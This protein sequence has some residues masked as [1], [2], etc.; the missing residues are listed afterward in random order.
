[1]L[2]QI[3]IRRNNKY[4]RCLIMRNCLVLFQ[5]ICSPRELQLSRHKNTTTDRYRDRTSHV[6]PR[7]LGCI[8]KR[9]FRLQS[10]CVWSRKSARIWLTLTGT[11]YEGL[12][13]GSKTL[14]PVDFSQSA[15]ISIM[16]RERVNW[17]GQ[18]VVQGCWCTFGPP[19]VPVRGRG[20]SKAADA[21]WERSLSQVVGSNKQTAVVNQVNSGS[22]LA[23]SR[24]LRPETAAH[25]PGFRGVPASALQ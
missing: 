16:V 21:R 9:T 7:H 1:M 19:P 13:T 14:T 4:K 18:G 10:W 23:T 20:W 24:T 5:K 3:Y 2:V 8:T 17:Q 25:P 22:R 6:S 12:T 11:N 15:V